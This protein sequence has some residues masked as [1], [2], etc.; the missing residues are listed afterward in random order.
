M[1]EESFDFV[2]IGGG[3]AGYAGASMAAKLGM[4]TALVEGAREMGGLC[5]LRGCMPSK[6]LIQSANR[7]RTLR[8]AKEFGL[9]AEAIEVRG[10]EILARKRRLVGEFAEYRRK[11]LDAGPFELIRGWAKFI[12]AHTLEVDGR[13]I[14]AKSFLIATGSSLK[15][16]E[17]PGLMETGFLDSDSVLETAHI[18]KSVIML[19]AG[20][21]ALEF[22]HYYNALGS[23]V[24]VIQRGAQVLREMDGDVAMAA[25]DALAARGVK[26]YLG[27]TLKSAEKTGTGKRI[28]FEH[29]GEARTVEA[30]E[31]VY[32]LGRMPN[33]GQL[34][35][36]NAGV[37]I[38][39]GRLTVMPTQQTSVPHIFAAGD[40][41]GPHEIVHIAI[42]QAEVA[43]HNARRLLQAPGEGLEQMDYRLKLFVAFTEPQVAAIGF[44]EREL[45]TANAPYAV[46]R[47][48]F[49]DH[50]KAE[51]IGETEGFVKLI[52]ATGSCEILGAAAV[53]PEAG[54]LI[55][56]LAA[57]IYFRATA[58]DLLRIP[59]YHPTLSEIWTYP[60]E[61]LTMPEA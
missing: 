20:P 9:R 61:E 56:E 6:T 53:G 51:V 50:G 35:V 49:A 54:E 39:H 2:V 41:A 28:V 33:I 10:E 8:R 59:H 21:I 13:R 12:D 11:Q 31:I 45:M 37:H 60:A 48:A 38:Q 58:H 22:A 5:I 24:T 3:S 44:T 47:Y 30:E 4:K 23:E 52:A 29:C 42:Q 43:A 18:P 57:A 27:T 46:A 15:Y 55:H 32:G 34:G 40:S 19:G 1:S 14:T 7:Y 17:I 16:V 36:E 25:S 26:F